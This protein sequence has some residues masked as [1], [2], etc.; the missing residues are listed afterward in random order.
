MN[1]TTFID[2]W[3]L[4]RRNRVVPQDQRKD[5]AG[6]HE[7]Q[8][9]EAAAYEL[10]KDPTSSSPTKNSSL[11]RTESFAEAKEGGTK[12]AGTGPTMEYTSGKTFNG[13][14]DRTSD[15]PLEENSVTETGEN[16]GTATGLL[17]GAKSAK[18]NESPWMTNSCRDDTGERSAPRIRFD[19]DPPTPFNSIQGDEGEMLRPEVNIFSPRKLAAQLPASTG[20]LKEPRRVSFSEHDSFSMKF[21]KWRRDR[22]ECDG[23]SESPWGVKQDST[24]K[25]EDNSTPVSRMVAAV[26]RAQKESSNS[27]FERRSWLGMIGAPNAEVDDDDMSDSSEQREMTGDDFVDFCAKPIERSRNIW[28]SRKTRKAK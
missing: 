28:N 13:T 11:N 9:G 25:D 8:R 26:R 3:P 12:E 22:D 21:S 6:G 23:G 27:D 24:F 18:F 7:K 20:R 4:A 1:M 15:K 10:E 19:V 5:P 14:S 16:T 17:L 2:R